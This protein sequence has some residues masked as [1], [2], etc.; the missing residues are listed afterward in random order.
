MDPKRTA[1]NG[2]WNDWTHITPTDGP[3][4]DAPGDMVAFECWFST[5]NDAGGVVGVVN[6]HGDDDF[7]PFRLGQVRYGD[8]IR[9]F[10]RTGSTNA[11]VR[12]VAYRLV[13]D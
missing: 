3:A 8:G 13:G 12:V 11:N 7:L 4:G 6:R 1:Y 5:G 2:T 9:R 10:R